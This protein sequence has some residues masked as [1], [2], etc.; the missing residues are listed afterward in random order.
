MKG[1]YILPAAVGKSVRLHLQG[2]GNGL[3][4]RLRPPLFNAKSD[5]GLVNLLEIRSQ[6]EALSC[7]GLQVWES[8][9]D[10]G[11]KIVREVSPPF[12]AFLPT[13]FKFGFIASPFA[14]GLE[15]L[16]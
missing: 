16:S 13:S 1:R 6:G 3:I 12:G 11:L 4:Q 8:L 10:K 2:S 7:F 5:L 14:F 15:P 9:V